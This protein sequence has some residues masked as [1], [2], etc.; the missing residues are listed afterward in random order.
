MF[1]NKKSNLLTRL[2]LP[3]PNYDKTKFSRKIFFFIENKKRKSIKIMEVNATYKNTQRMN[4]NIKKQFP[5]A[6]CKTNRRAVRSH[7]K[8]EDLRATSDAYRMLSILQERI[9]RSL[10]CPQCRKTA[11]R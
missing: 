10:C 3:I 4:K 9:T 11:Q 7:W 5:A 6:V 1:A 2:Y 8:M